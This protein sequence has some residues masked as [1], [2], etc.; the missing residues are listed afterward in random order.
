MYD[1]VLQW[2]LSIVSTNNNYCDGDLSN[3]FLIDN[4]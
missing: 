1:D 4:S 2:S 3:L